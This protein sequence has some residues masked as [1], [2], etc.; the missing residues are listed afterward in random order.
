ML[1]PIHVDAQDGSGIRVE[2]Q[3]LNCDGCGNDVFLIYQIAGQKHPH[4]QCEF[5]GATVC[6]QAG[7]CHAGG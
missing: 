3:K 1:E 6:S 4:Y 7:E 5:C 2:A